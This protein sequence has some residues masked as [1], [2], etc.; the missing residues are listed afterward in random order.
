MPTYRKL[1][2]KTLESQEL[3]NMPNDL[4]RLTWVL[5]PLILSR[6]GTT[7]Y[8]PHY[9]SC[10][11]YPLRTDVCDEEMALIFYWFEDRGLIKPYT[12]NG[13]RY[14]YVPSFHDDQGECDKEMASPYPPVPPE[15][16]Q[17][18]EPPAPTPPAGSDTPTSPDPGQSGGERPLACAGATPEKLQSSSRVT[19]EKLQSNSTLD[20]DIEIE[21]ERE[22]DSETGKKSLRPA[23][24]AP[25]RVSSLDPP[26]DARH[27]QALY[28][29][30]QRGTGQ[31]T[32][33]S[34]P[35][36]LA[37]AALRQL[38]E[39]SYTPADV[40]ACARYLKRGWW[41]DKMLTLP[42]VA[43]TIGQWVAQGR[44]CAPSPARG[45]ADRGARTRRSLD[46][47]EVS[48]WEV[49]QI[50]SELRAMSAAAGTRRPPVYA[51]SA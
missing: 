40:E 27:L 34:L 32:T 23:Q 5:L 2:T 26:R 4:Y 17:D 9:L 6:E 28:Q 10:K 20:I 8:Q 41:R 16:R 46:V 19:P 3:A 21:T 29:A 45:S 14:L 51:P 33:N 35:T 24:S 48:A 13:R 50:R 39:E 1:N 43:D 42:K 31:K 15:L 47:V 49:E 22:K 30:F 38:M 12:V 25:A 36:G 11:L 7:I 37:R 18:E 44:L